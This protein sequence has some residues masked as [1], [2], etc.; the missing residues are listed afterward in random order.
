MTVL[1]IVIAVIFSAAAAAVAACVFAVNSRGEAFVLPAPLSER[2]ML[3][4][5]RS[6]TGADERGTARA[7][8]ALAAGYLKRAYR[9]LVVKSH[10]GEELEDYERIFADNYMNILI[11]EREVGDALP[12]L[13]R[14]PVRKEGGILAFASVVVRSTGGATD[15]EVFARCAAMLGA[16]KS[17]TWN[18]LKALRPALRLALLE[19][20]AVYASKMLFR[21]RLA[22]RAAKD[23]KRGKA[24]PALCAYAS[25]VRAYSAGGDIPEGRDAYS[26]AA[27]DDAMLAEYAAG[28]ELLAAAL[29]RD[30]VTDELLVS[31][32]SPAEIYLSGGCGFEDLSLR[33]R[34]DM[35][36]LT[37]RYAEKHKVSEERAA[38]EVVERS[39]AEGKD[40]SE[41][42]I[43]DAPRYMLAVRLCLSIVLT[44][45]TVA[46][47]VVF[48]PLTGAVAAIS[49][50][51]AIMYAYSALLLRILAGA[52]PPVPVPEMKE[53]GNRS[54]AIVICVALRSRGDLE[55]AFGKLM[56]LECTAREKIFSYGILADIVSGEYTAEE[57]EKDAR[58][59]IRG[60]R[61]FFLLRKSAVGRK[62]GALSA[63]NK[64]VLTG[65]MSAYAVT[66][67]R[68]KK[69][70]YVIT[71]DSDTSLTDAERLVRI[72][73]HPYNRRYAVMSLDM[74]PSLGGMTTPLSA[75]VGGDGGL[76]R[77][78]GAC[79]AL[80][81]LHGYTCYCGKGIYRVREFYERA[82]KT[83][84]EDK[85]LSHDLIEGA[86]AGCGGSG[87]CALEEAPRTSGAYW[88]RLERWMRGDIQS[89]PYFRR[90][91]P[92]D[93]GG[94]RGISVPAAAKAA[95]AENVLGIVYAPMSL[96]SLVLALVSGA[97][98]LLVLPLM[99]QVCEIVTACTGLFRS[100]VKA[101]RSAAHAALSAVYLPHRAFVSMTAVT[102]ALVS[103]IRGKDLLRWNVYSPSGDG[104]PLFVANFIAGAVCATIFAFTSHAAAIVVAA[105]FFAALPLDLF[106]S[107]EK[108]VRALRDGFLLSL[109]GKTS[110]YFAEALAA[111]GDLPPDNHDEDNGWAM[112]SSPTD[113][114]M[115]MS[116]AVCAADMGIISENERDRAVAKVLSGIDRAEKFRGCPYNWYDVSGRPLP[117]KYV[118]SV[119]CGNLLAALIHV[120]STGG[121]NAE[122]A[123]RL[124]ENM[125]MSFLFDD[126]GLLH[127]GCDTDKMRLD[128]GKYDLLASECALS[129]LVAFATG[130]CDD[131]G[132]RT[133]SRLA[134][135]GA[136]RTLASWTGGAFEYMLPLLYFRAPERSLLSV[137][138]TGA[139]RMQ[140]K[141]AAYCRSPLWGASE[142]LYGEKYSNGDSK[143]KAFGA[144]SAALS[145]CGDRAVFAPYASVMCA[146]VKR[147]YAGELR[148]MLEKYMS[149]FGLYDSLDLTSGSVQRACM[150][151]HQGMIMLALCELI[152]P[153]KTY[154]RMSGHPGVRAASLQLEE[155]SD[156]LRGALRKPAPTAAE[157]SPAE[158]KRAY[159]RSRM[160]DINLLS[161][162]DYRLILDAGGRSASYVGNVCVSRFDD[163]RGL[164]VIA[165]GGGETADLAAADE[166]IHLAHA[167][168]YRSRAR[169]FEAE[170]LAAVLPGHNAE[171]RR[172]TLR[173]KTK[174]PIVMSVIVQITPCLTDR[175]ADLAHKTYSRMF[176][177]TFRDGKIDC[178]R[179]KRRG[180]ETQAALKIYLPAEYYGDERNMLGG[181]A[182]CFGMT[183]ECILGG[184]TNIVLAPLGQR[185]FDI[186]LACGDRYDTDNV[187]RLCGDSGYIDGRLAAARAAGKKNAIPAVW[188]DVASAL[189]FGGAENGAPRKLTLVATD[190][191]LTRALAAM[192]YLGEAEKFGAA[193][194][195]TVLC[196]I[197]AAYSSTGRIRLY[198]AASRMGGYCSIEDISAGMTV[199]G[200][201]ALAEGTDVRSLT[202]LPLPPFPKACGKG[203]Y[204]SLPPAGIPLRTAL[205][206]GGFTDDGEYFID[207]ATPSPW[208]NV[209]SD[210]SVGCL[211]SD[212]GEYTFASNSREEKL[213]RH[214]CDELGDLHGDG[215]VLGENGVIWSPS[216]SALIGGAD[217]CTV[218]HSPG[219]TVLGT[220]YASLAVTRTVFVH[221]GAKYSVVRA[222]NRT[223]KR[224]TVR[225]M[226]F[227]ELV[228]GD[229]RQ[230]TAGGISRTREGNALHARCGDL[231][232]YLTATKEPETFALSSESY[233]DGSGRIRTCEPR[234]ANGLTPAL[235][236]SVKLSLPPHG[237]GEV[238]FALST[239]KVCVT[240]SGAAA[241]FEEVKSKFAH[242]PEAESNEAPVGYYLKWLSYQAYIARFTAKCGF[243]QPG[244]ATGFRDTLQDSSAILGFRPKEVRKLLV[245]CAA[246]QFESGDV[247]HWWH[248]PATGVR[249]RICDDRLFL[250]WALAE[251]IS[252]TSD[253]GV[254][255]E[256]VPYL[257]DV[258]IP[259]GENSVYGSM[260]ES[261]RRV[262][263]REHAMSAIRSVKLSE[264]GL[265]LMG[266]GDWNDGMNGV[267]AGGKGESVWC[268]MFLYYVAGR[269]LPYSADG[270]RHYLA[271]LRSRLL[272]AIAACRRS[273]RYVR[274]Y[275]DEGRAIGT[276]E[277]DECSSDLLV[278]AWSVL[279]GIECGD[280]ARGILNAAW[281]RLHDGEHK[282]LRLL[283]PPI[284][285]RSVGYIADYPPGVRENGGQYTH[286]AV[287]FLRAMY[288]AGQDE[289]ANGL[290]LELLP[291]THTADVE[292]VET[293]LKEPYVIAGDVYSGELAGRGGWT[294]YTGAA[295]WMYRTLLEYYY[296]VTVKGDAVTFRPRMTHGKADLRLR[297]KGTAFTLSIVAEGCGER[298]LKI[299][300]VSYSS[301]R[302]RIAS[303]EGRHVSITRARERQR[304]S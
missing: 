94:K 22:V 143:Y 200:E 118:S 296:G 63:F 261:R 258:R 31:L 27:E 190:I 36:M 83:L 75:L 98:P 291:C 183:T 247:M 81:R 61:T 250:P 222:E 289:K 122:K 208:Y 20:A 156:A 229:M 14:L 206:I 228:M 192:K 93:G 78:G 13:S 142:S 131:K 284:T 237:C 130:K 64:S 197:K 219:Y 62:R 255:N 185:T 286:A 33:T 114:G 249:T 54:T 140:R 227:A 71:L 186:V 188:R 141:Y 162:G 152:A 132:Y 47:A 294:W 129:Y 178:V 260:S 202:N 42:L 282:L 189:I 40:I 248:E 85:L 209:M 295:G 285:D 243:Q 276:E 263:V 90:N 167:S 45:S 100:P 171:L 264:R 38:R 221:G 105:V 232:A 25:Y 87:V 267:G 164:A 138:A 67:G 135:S 56:T 144:P 218:L 104:R 60:K 173:N 51:P 252:Y 168:I 280:G 211:V 19:T 70:E 270:D 275:D 266:S 2:E 170:V 299:D 262:S 6:L 125:D 115:A 133:L 113:M 91:A 201:R 302:F 176:I 99:P 139:V 119:D 283:W 239:K 158:E 268:S 220:G 147:K 196:R 207:A 108:K 216:R 57:A 175:M 136:G 59:L 44:A 273:D 166:C 112:R 58:R 204:P 198:D 55:S 244:G 233:R 155:P 234:E 16:K 82:G 18:E 235:A 7:N 177:Q 212:K 149:P 92:D 179:A 46:A 163:L 72:M 120:M 236:L 24:A 43:P 223:S 124:A 117:P 174:R 106:L 159:V 101:A 3:A 254:L 8:F 89:L 187:L 134:L 34:T 181:R 65:D 68:P 292:G 293:Y 29:R 35:L 39:R 240:E 251:Y 193:F 123:G 127:I 146:G 4:A 74:R 15:P 210:G 154:E 180:S 32:S 50:A 303:L 30:V 231:D 304:N 271:T 137:S 224:R 230:R 107:R 80:R 297:I 151:H 226:Y 160:P 53:T 242:L 259:D 73:E 102:A 241:A 272:P 199:D 17:L 279:S 79:G 269:F 77:Y 265:V 191:G 225:V 277:Y 257:E 217:D 246:H 157:E 298:E 300:G 214:S 26:A 150:T 52:F 111:G 28:M 245:A 41:Y 10:S 148:R 145:M 5:V 49:A 278:A 238:T 128:E 103:M 169:R 97:I 88:S 153:G 172:I 76:V 12:A 109:A 121:E 37:G 256:I 184:K 1:L 96:I 290:L 66:A 165:V 161:S 48:V 253:S 287:W 110:R 203:A 9:M 11:A 84:P 301:D 69:F 195:L 95:A 205:G 182:P 274:A 213:T 21:R 86:L 215:I 116:A 126:N 23:A 281:A 194:R 288:D